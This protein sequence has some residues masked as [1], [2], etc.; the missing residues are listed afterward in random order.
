MLGVQYLGGMAIYAFLYRCPITGHKVQGTTPS[1]PDDAATY[2]TVTCALCNRVHLINPT[3]GH[4][5][6][7]STQKP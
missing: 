7:V 1:A 5:A 2:E 4:V 3:T 6:G